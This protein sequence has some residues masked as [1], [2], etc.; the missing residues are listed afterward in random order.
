MMPGSFTYDLPPGWVRFVKNMLL[1]PCIPALYAAGAVA[2]YSLP[3]RRKQFSDVSRSNPRFWH[4]NI[5]QAVNHWVMLTREC[6]SSTP[7]NAGCG[8]NPDRCTRCP[9]GHFPE[10]R[11]RLARGIALRPWINWVSAPTCIVFSRRQSR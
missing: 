9:D 3:P 10:Q 1:P 8:R 5:V 6:E 2:K 7:E 11:I 4:P